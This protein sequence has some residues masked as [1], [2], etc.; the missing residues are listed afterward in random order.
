[1][2]VTSSTSAIDGEPEA[3]NRRRVSTG[4]VRLPGTLAAP[5]PERIARVVAEQGLDTANLKIST[6]TDI[7][8]LGRYD[9]AWLVLGAER[10]LVVDDVRADVRLA[11]E[12][13]S[14]REF[15]TLA[16]VGSGLLQAKV[17]DLYVDV[18][19]YSNREAYRFERAAHKLDRSLHGEPLD[20]GPEDEQDPRRCPSCGLMLEALGESC[21]R[22]VPRGAVLGRLL[23]LMRPY[24]GKAIAM[25][26]LLLLGVALDLVSPQ[27][28]RYLVDRVLPG[29]RDAGAPSRAAAAHEL[30]QTLLLVVVVLALVQ[31]ARMGVNALNGRLSSSIGTAITFDM[32]TRLAEHLQKLGVGFYDRQQV[33]S[34]SARVAYDTE[35]IHDFMWQLTGGFILQLFMVVGVF[36]MMFTI[37][38]ELALLAL[39]PAPVVMGATLFFWKRIYPL[40]YRTWEASSRQAGTLTS[41]LAGIRVVKA[42]GQER[43][44]GE[45]FHAASDRLRVARH[46]VDA[47][48]ATFNPV[49]GVLFQIGGWFVW[50]FGGK[51]VIGRDL[52]LGEL[53]AFFGYLWMFY[54]PLASLPQFTS[55]LTQTAT[56]AKRIF[57]VLDTPITLTDA[58]EPVSVTPLAGRIEFEDVTFGYTPH[59]PVLRNV[60]FEIEPGEFVGIVG[61]SGSGKTTTVNLISRFYDVS[62][63][64][65]LVDGVDVR[66]I[67]K[68]ELRSQIGVVLQEPFLFRGTICENVAYGNPGA[69]PERVIRAARAAN[70]HDFILR[71]PH[72]YDT[73]LG[74]GGAGLSGGE[75]QRIAI[76]RALLVEPR[77]LILDEAT[78]NID[79]ESEAAIQSALNDLVRGRTTIAI[80]HRLSTL[81]RA[82][83]IIVM[84]RGQIIEIGTH[85]ELI[86]RDGKYARL[87]KL[88]GLYSAWPPATGEPAAPNGPSNGRPSLPPM[89][90][91]VSRWLTPALARVEQ[92]VFGTL[93]IHV[94]GEPAYRGAYCVR[95][96][97]IHHPQRFISIWAP[98][99]DGRDREVGLIDDLS[100]FSA[101]E[102]RLIRESLLRRYFVQI[103]TDISGIELRGDHLT[104]QVTTES[105][106]M[107]FTIRWHPDR[108]QDYGE[109]GRM[110]MDTEENRYV[111]WNVHA[112]GEHSRKLL[113]KYIYW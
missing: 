56:Q 85:A 12:V 32:R 83:R 45:R 52:T 39:L 38:P 62:R 46:R 89:T 64:R 60:S 49:V 31:M 6:Q 91:H 29:T 28:T 63:G 92:G 11:L 40:Y 102:Q 65:V 44:E 37:E 25:M 33:G 48:I 42:F 97:P 69:E 93:E 81:R 36:V 68:E 47:A 54:G 113:E 90:G 105:G 16:G 107:E 103:I 66:Q 41:L 76:A 95:C 73:W 1:M 27:L 55:W 100:E 71:R 7:D 4:R 10:L 15:R 79:A 74:E 30:V 13:P 58:K 112:L 43:R 98:G 19:R 67:A 101:D 22:C 5:L 111:V 84:E 50:Y 14:I 110:F 86:A 61:G 78:S 80:A 20:L 34:L 35:V 70:C 23:S 88:Q 108:A 106:P 75:K 18:L 26:G 3:P 87:L 94:E 59:T 72:G 109:H 77:V 24:R 2:S 104:L 9:P 8:Q 21:P 57:E 99:A 82:D 96:M 17:G 53:M 51:S